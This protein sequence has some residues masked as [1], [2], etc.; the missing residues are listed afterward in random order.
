MSNISFEQYLEQFKV[1]LVRRYNWTVTDA[2]AYNDN[3][4]VEA[5]KKG[6]SVREA[7]WEIFD[8]SQDEQSYGDGHDCQLNP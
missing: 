1:M 7:Y 3:R 8:V 6:F 2:A 5:H 4:L